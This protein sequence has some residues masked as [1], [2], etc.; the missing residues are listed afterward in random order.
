MN[1]LNEAD[2]EE[3]IQT[4]LGKLG[5]LS[6]D[7][8]KYEP[9]WQQFITMEKHKEITTNISK[10]ICKE[11]QRGFIY[12][13]FPKTK[14]SNEMNDSIVL[15]QALSNV[16]SQ[17]L[18]V[19]AILKK[20]I[21]EG[22]RNALTIPP[23]A[24]YPNTAFGNFA[25]E[26]SILHDDKSQQEVTTVN[27]LP[28]WNDLPIPDGPENHTEFASKEGET[29]DGFQ[30]IGARVRGKKHKHEA[31]NCDD[32]FEFDGIGDWTII[33]VSD[34]AGSRKLSRIGSKTS[35]Q[36]A[37][38]YLKEKLADHTL[39]ERGEWTN[40]DFTRNASDG[41]FEQ[42]DIEYIQ[43]GLHGAMEH[44]FQAVVTAAADRSDNPEYDAMLERKLEVNDLSSTLLLAV[45]VPAK[46]GAA[47]RSLIMTCQIG[48]G[49]I[50]ALRSDGTLQLLGQADS[51]EFSGETDFL[52]S[53]PKV[54]ANLWQKTFGFFGP[55]QALMV[56]TDG[57]ADD[58]FPN[59]PG[60]IRLY[61]DLLLNQIVPLPD[62]LAANLPATL[63]DPD[64]QIHSVEE[65][66]N[67]S[68][69]QYTVSRREE[70]IILR[71]AGK[72]AEEYGIPAETLIVK[73]ELILAG[74]R[75]KPM[76]QAENAADR[77]QV[78]LDS[79]EVRGSFDDRTLVVMYPKEGVSNG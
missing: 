49:M 23:N 71:H 58:Y 73:P 7:S 26:A 66:E 16:A 69:F 78:W 28:K 11:L 19:H 15:W 65:L 57:V 39:V 29:V 33:A 46:Q 34:G 21:E 62:V 3:F 1:Y 40:Q 53:Y 75:G 24:S 9:I 51:G 43:A 36:A 20:K 67:N 12:T 37:I 2:T 50:G 70:E 30:L 68:N 4:F 55:L 38:Q 5:I 25:V 54:Q 14:L 59:S 63:A 13:L 18:E 72:L 35:C 22:I 60:L 64:L 77:L 61:A 17:N 56:M 45:I 10:V 52:T 79:Y 41:I 47:D 6:L 76:C 74:A 27:V 48:D 42:A 44:A 31:T 32:W 8:A